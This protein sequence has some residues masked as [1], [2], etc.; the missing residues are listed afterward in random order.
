WIASVSLG[1]DADGKRVVKRASGR[2]K[3]EAKAKLKELLRLR[4][5]GPEE[6]E[7]VPA[8]P[9]G[10]EPEGTVGGAVEN[11]LRY[12]LT[13]KDPATVANYTTLCGTH[14]LPALGHLALHELHVDHVDAWLAA[15]AKVL[16]TRTLKAIHSCLSRAVQR[17]VVR[18]KVSRNVVALCTVPPGRPGR[19]SKALTYGQ[20][21]A[22]L[23]GIEGDPM[24]A[25]IVLSLLTGAR[26]EELRPLTWDHVHLEGQPDAEPP[27]PP[28]IAV[29]RS[30][31]TGGDTKTHRSRRTL[32]L[33]ARCVTALRCHRAAQERQRKQAGGSW[34]QAN[35]VFTS[36]TGTELDAAN[37]RRAFR[38]AI[39]KA[40]GIN[41][42]E[43]TSRELRTSFV[44][45]LSDRGGLPVEKIAQLVGHASTST[46]E[47]IY[48]KQ[49]RPVI[50]TGAVAIDRVFAQERAR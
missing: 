3:T 20:A 28:H 18:D 8:M 14:I 41:P 47:R 13:D 16:S 11:W 33:P 17:A 49:I 5:M 1:Y 30:V 27:I 37:V 31:R 9:A 12:G 23:K 19:P 48:R 26:T 32:A 7:V 2:T 29:W 34:N 25:Y 45:L 39:A 44:S 50:Q 21:K 42:H 4:E 6:A 38:R 24:E 22:I 46:T 40:E 15:K 10:K 36:A 43:W 35:L